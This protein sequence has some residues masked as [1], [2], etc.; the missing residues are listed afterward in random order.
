MWH[1]GP[2]C[3]EWRLSRGITQ[4][5]IARLAGCNRSFVCRYEKGEVASN[6]LLFIYIREGM[7][8]T[9]EQ[10]VEYLGGGDRTYG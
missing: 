9:Q 6:H 10:L 2:V 1:L 7:P 4:A 3:R 5:H 8:I